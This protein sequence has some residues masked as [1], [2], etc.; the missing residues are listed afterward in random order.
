VPRGYEYVKR[1][2]YD[3]RV[4]LF[5]RF[6]LANKPG[7]VKYD[8]YDNAEMLNLALLLGDDRFAEDL[9]A[10]IQRHFCLGEDVYSV[11]DWLGRHKNRNM[12][13]WAVMPYLLAL[14]QTA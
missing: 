8:L 4:G 1:A 6:S 10:A 12:L 13:R 2:L 3:V 11:I 7:L 9:G 5:R 14:S